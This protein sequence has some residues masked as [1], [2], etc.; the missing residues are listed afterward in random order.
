[1]A[2]TIKQAR[3]VLLGY[4]GLTEE[5]ANF[6]PDTDNWG[7]LF[8]K[9]SQKYVIFIMPLGENTSSPKI[10]F[11]IR[12]SGA[13]K[14]VAAWK[15]AEQNNLKFF[16]LGVKDEIEKYKNYIISVEADIYTVLKVSGLEYGRRS[17]AGTQLNVPSSLLPEGNITRAKSNKFDIFFAVI[18]KDY[19][20]TYLEV[21]DNRLFQFI[22]S[23]IQTLEEESIKIPRN[24][25]I[26]GAPGTGKSYKLKEESSVF[27]NQESIKTDITQQ[28]K[29][30][31]ASV[32]KLSGK[33]NY[34]GAI[35]IKYA[36]YLKGRTRKQLSTELNISSDELYIGSRAKDLAEKIIV[37]EDEEDKEKQIKTLVK[38]A[39]AGDNLLQNLMAIGIRFSDYLSENTMGDLKQTYGLTSDAQMWWLY[40]GTQA[41]QVLNQEPKK[42]PIKY[43]ERVTFHP[44]YS[45]A[46]FV[47][48]YKPIKSTINPEDI[49]YEYVPGPFMRTYVNAKKNDGKKFLL[50]IEEINR[51]NVAAVFGDIFQLLDRK[52]DGT[53]EYPITASEDQKQY[54]ESYGINET[55]ITIPSNMYIWATMNSADQGVLPMDA[56]FKRRWEFEY[57]NIDDGEAEL[58]GVT[59]PVPNGINEDK[60]INYVDIEWNTLRKA[61]NEQL[62]TVSGV[63]E[64][65]LLGPFFIGDKTK[66]TNATQD[67]EQFCKSFK[68][69]VLMYL[70]ED[71]VKMQP[72]ELFESKEG[73]NVHY[74]DICKDYDTKGLKIFVNAISDQFPE[75]NGEA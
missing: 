43:L 52:I 63:N 24:R 10:Y 34:L 25:I 47:G 32:I 18:K 48:T 39:Q 27:T 2:Y 17:G 65:K 14:F 8:E 7:I 73:V 67:K 68:S 35:G 42:Q 3:P 21:F 31:I 4:L 54:L 38:A 30:E 75:F 15:Y 26:F 66:V 33:L 45:F 11:D 22:N 28:I 20:F 1:M 61:I 72:G 50:L 36:D 9:N 6:I 71:V 56:A 49:T 12:D 57:I 53:S 51:A 59:I 62:K 46:Q 5:T 44:N 58:N 41:I 60:T 23:T 70:F 19:I 40:R 13:E 37:N 16:C 74:S 69:K 55:E 29:D 64:D